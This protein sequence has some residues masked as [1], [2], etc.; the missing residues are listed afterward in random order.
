MIDTIYIE[1][2][3]RDHPRTRSILSRFNK[4]R[5]I[6]IERYG[7]V[8]NKRAQ[9]FRLQKFK[10]ALILARKHAGHILRVFGLIL[11]RV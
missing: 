2:D 1:E 3:V 11:E 10:P 7:E 5:H 6:S 9:N 8:F 4:A